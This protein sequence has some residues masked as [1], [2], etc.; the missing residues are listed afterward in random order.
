MSASDPV[1][2]ARA[3]RETFPPV[4]LK[5][6]RASGS[7][8][9]REGEEFLAVDSAGSIRLS[10]GRIGPGGGKGPLLHPLFY[11]LTGFSPSR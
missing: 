5:P 10:G 3:E 7:W 11:G 2:R 6:R 9:I 8:T 1:D 4:A